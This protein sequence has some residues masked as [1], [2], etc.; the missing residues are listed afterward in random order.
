MIAQS[1]K[2][3][4]TSF[5]FTFFSQTSERLLHDCRSPAKIE[6]PLGRKRVERAIRDRQ[7]RGRFCHPSVP[8]NELNTTASL[9]RLF[10]V[11]HVVKE[12]LERLEQE[13]AEAASALVGLSQPVSF[14]NHQEKILRK[15]LRVFRR[16]AAAADIGKNGSPVS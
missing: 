13:R 7:L 8:R 11:G 3:A 4:E 2:K 15:V 1:F 12:I 6:Q 14:Q 10:L 9:Q 5:P 16:I